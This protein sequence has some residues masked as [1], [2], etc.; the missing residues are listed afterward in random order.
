VRI[1]TL[2]RESLHVEIAPDFG[3]AVTTFALTGADGARVALLREPVGT[4][5][6]PDD[7]A[8]FVLAPWS[9]RIAGA[10][11]RFAGQTHALN[12]NEPG[13]HAHHGVVR[14]HTLRIVDRT[15]YSATL[16]FD[17]RDAAGAVNFPFMFDARVR[18]ELLDDGLECSIRLA[19]TGDVDMPAGG[20][21]HPFFPRTLDDTRDACTLRSRVRARYPL[22]ACVPTGPA[23]PD[24]LCAALTRGVPVT[25]L[26][27][28]DDVFAGFEGPAEITWPAS[29]VSLTIEPSESLGHL[30]VYTPNAPTGGPR[31]WF[32]VEPVTH[33][34]DAFNMHARGIESTGARSLAPGETLDMTMALR[35]NTE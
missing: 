22:D 6:R 21:F 1:I 10:A 13:G 17:S 30:V 14:D 4:P 16:L 26:G 32:C 3:G 20:G 19:N 33:A 27:E 5:D 34:T 8:M 28:L 11:L 2:Q 15:P 12:V 25:E 18:Y 29:G 7:A 31:P 23:T 9:N 24:D 35:V